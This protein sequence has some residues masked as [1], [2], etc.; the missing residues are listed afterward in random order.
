MAKKIWNCKSYN[1]VKI[2]CA[3]LTQ[4]QFY[5]E[6]YFTISGLLY[7]YKKQLSHYANKK[8][9]AFWRVLGLHFNSVVP[10]QKWCGGERVYK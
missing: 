3:P 6:A 9:Q 1:Y 8:V 2:N 10:Y 7:K 4:E 5:C